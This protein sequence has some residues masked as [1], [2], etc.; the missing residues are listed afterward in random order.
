[1]SPEIHFSQSRQLRLKRKHD[2]M[3]IRHTEREIFAKSAPR[4]LF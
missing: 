3:V 4:P 2:P 1:M